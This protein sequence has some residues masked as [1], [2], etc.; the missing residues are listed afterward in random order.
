MAVGLLFDG[1]GVSQD[2]YYQVLN[3]VT[4]NGA[5]PPAGGLTHVAGPTESGF[6]VIETWE[7]REALEAFYEAKLRPAL[8]AAQIQVQPKIFDVINSAP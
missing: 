6:C 5:E 1:V 8:E 7:S 2:Q 4:N 3:E